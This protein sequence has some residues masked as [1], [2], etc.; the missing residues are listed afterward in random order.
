[1]SVKFKW[2]GLA[3]SDKLL[4]FGASD[5]NQFATFTMR[6]INS[7][8]MICF[9]VQMGLNEIQYMNR[10]LAKNKGKEALQYIKK[11]CPVIGFPSEHNTEFAKRWKGEKVE[12]KIDN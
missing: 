9:E 12:I 4:E 7:S 5:S 10:L 11:K 8:D 3:T 1:M 6:A 2:A